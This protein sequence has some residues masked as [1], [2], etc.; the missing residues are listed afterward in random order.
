MLLVLSLQL[1]N[2]SLDSVRGSGRTAWLSNKDFALLV[3]DK[4]AA[5][6]TLGLL[7]QANGCDESRLGVAQEGV[8][9]LLLL[10]ESGVCLG[11]VGAQAKDGKAISSQRLIGIAEE[12]HLGGA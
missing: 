2:Q 6:S 3:D 9:Q 8:R 5:L 4:D 7:L 1:L 11:R 10:L 12:A